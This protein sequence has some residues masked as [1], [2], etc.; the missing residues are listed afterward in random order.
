VS[1][2]DVPL[3]IRGKVIEEDW[4]EFGGRDGSGGF[5]APDPHK[6]VDQL[7]L[8]SPMALQDMHDISFDEILDVL[9]EL[10]KK[11]DFDKNP[12]IRQA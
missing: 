7:P 4:V 1:A 6:Y 2:F 10:G 12:Y 3:F 11:L 9:E 5:R 8:A